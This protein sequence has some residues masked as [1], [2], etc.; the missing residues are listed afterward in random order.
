MGRIP[1]DVL[2]GLGISGA[3]VV[4]MPATIPNNGRAVYIKSVERNME[5]IVWLKTWATE[6]GTRVAAGNNVM[7][8][9]P[10]KAQK[11]Y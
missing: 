6:I 4:R 2:K 9:Y 1:M 8:F 10:F 5:Q 11:T 7:V 3:F